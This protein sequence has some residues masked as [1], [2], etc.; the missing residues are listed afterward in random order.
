M[1]SDDD[2]IEDIL[3]MAEEIAAIV[4]LGQAEF[5][6]NIIV[7][8]AAERCL[9]ILG[10]AVKNVSAEVRAGFADLQQ[11]KDAAGQRDQLAHRYWDTDNGR[12]WVAITVSVPEF[13]AGVRAATGR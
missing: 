12:L 13:A 1:R 9:G 11:I 5:E 6:S 3:D 2:R 10:E 7:R 8:R 4:A